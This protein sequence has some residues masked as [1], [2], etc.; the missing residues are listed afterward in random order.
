MP[1]NTG[2]LD[3]P[4]PGTNHPTVDRNGGFFGDAPSYSLGMRKAV[5]APVNAS[6]GPS[7]L[8]KVV[9]AA[10]GGPI[11]DAPAFS[12]GTSERFGAVKPGTLTGGP[13]ETYPNLTRVGSSMSLGGDAPMYGFGTEL[14][15]AS[16][17]PPKRFIS[18]DISRKM[19]AGVNS[20][21]PVYHWPDGIGVVLVGKMAP[22]EPRYTMRPRLERKPSKRE[23]PVPGPGAYV[24]KPTIGP[25]SEH[26]P[27]TEPQFSFGK[28]AR[29]AKK[30]PYLGK[31]YEKAMG[32]ARNTPGPGTYKH[33]WLNGA[34]VPQ[35]KAAPSFSFGS[36]SRF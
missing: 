22:N 36:D 35:Y 24:S 20:P 28:E 30:P 16:S 14:R 29:P 15:R 25:G 5:P 26:H 18:R 32:G 27:N 13:G 7:Y 9:T 4:G 33:A 12:C 21:G 11:G 2:P 19:M 31:A 34:P 1:A 8:P 10:S 3:Y 17:A 6:P 23:K